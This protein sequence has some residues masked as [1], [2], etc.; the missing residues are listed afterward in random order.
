MTV[1]VLLLPS[2]ATLMFI[3]SAVFDRL[4]SEF[5]CVIASSSTGT[6]QEMGRP[7]VGPGTVTNV[8]KLPEM[9]ASGELE[10][11]SFPVRL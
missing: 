9:L 7:I 4:I 6:V 10:I 2:I 1:V 5:A 11:P 3:S 8:L